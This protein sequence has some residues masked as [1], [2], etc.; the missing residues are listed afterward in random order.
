HKE[1]DGILM[2]NSFHY[3]KD[4]NGLIEKLKSFL[5]SDG[6]FLIVEYDTDKANRWVQFPLSFKNLTSLFSNNGFGLIEKIGERSSV[7]GPQKM[8]ASVI[9]F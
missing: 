1:L 8:Y 9:K 7:F 2:A 6:M 5:K 3:V 4:K